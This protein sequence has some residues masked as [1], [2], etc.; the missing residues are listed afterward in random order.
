MSETAGVAFGRLVALMA[1]LRAPD[2]CPWD[3][4][5]S[6]ES[7]RAYLIE[8]TYEVLEALDDGD[9]GAHREELG[10][11]LFQVVF[12]ARIREEEGH[13]D[14]AAVADGIR[15]KLERRHPHVFG[16][17]VLA[18]AEAVAQSW[19]AIKAQEKADRRTRRAARGLPDDSAKGQLDGVPPSL[20]SLSRALKLQQKAAKV[21][22]DWGAA[23]PVLDKI[24]EEIGELRAAIAGGNQAE[25]A[26][27][28]GDILFALVNLG[29][30]LK[31]EPEAALRATNEKFRRRF[32]HIEARLAEQDRTPDEAS[33]DEMEALW[34]E[35]KKLEQE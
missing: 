9:P 20:P 18:D 30:H 32:A 6:L 13:F 14:A 23:G 11:L 8:E 21:G 1:R 10:D 2:G 16:D 27:E 19:H 33:L 17:A 22:F 24:E 29:R 28:F 15:E 7:L 34:V 26:D 35:A 12:Q 4:R 31:V 3:R 25:A 5:Q